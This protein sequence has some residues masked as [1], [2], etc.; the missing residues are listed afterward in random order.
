MASQSCVGGIKLQSLVLC[1]AK[2]ATAT[3]SRTMTNMTNIYFSPSSLPVAED[4][5]VQSDP[6]CAHSQRVSLHNLRAIML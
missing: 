3:S 1:N 5:P 4:L 2:L 6:H